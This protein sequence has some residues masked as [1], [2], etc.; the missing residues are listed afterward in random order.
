MGLF[1]INCAMQQPA[2]SGPN[3]R[4]PIPVPDTAGCAPSRRTAQAR[5]V[6]V[7]RLWHVAG[8]YPA[9]AGYIRRYWTAALGP[10]AVA[11]LLR[12]IQAAKT[13]R[14]IRR[15]VRLPEL[16]KAGL[17]VERGDELLV[18]STVPNLPPALVRRLPAGLR[19]EIADGS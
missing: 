15:P 17:V 4:P 19:S 5:P 9:D 16:A 13:R 3:A 6:V 10:S 2:V 8:G 12:L 14:V 1:V 7:P 11:D 18:R